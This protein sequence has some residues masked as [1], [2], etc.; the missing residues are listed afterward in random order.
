MNKTCLC[1]KESKGIDLFVKDKYSK[2]GRKSRCL[3][4]ARI[5]DAEYHSKNKEKKLKKL[6]N[7]I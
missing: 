1:C 3:E 2:D 5:K 7:G 6:K 4:C